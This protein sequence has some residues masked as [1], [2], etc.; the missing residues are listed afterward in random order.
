LAAK[1]DYQD[2]LPVLIRLVLVLCT[3]SGTLGRLMEV[4]VLRRLL[5]YA[6][7]RAAFVR[8]GAQI[9]PDVAISYGVY[10]RSP[11]NVSIG[12]GTRLN[13][14]VRIESWGRVTIGR[15]CMFNDDILILTAQHDIDSVDFGPDIRPVA[16]GDYVWLPHRIVLLPGVQLG[17]AAVIGTGSVVTRNVPPYAIAAGNPA[18]VI[19]ERARLTFRYVPAEW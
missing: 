9:A 5:G 1:T 15:S 4:A 19:R 16:I 8:L 3:S 11:H 7:R 6:G 12:A 13:G 17:E 14:R 10:M 18:R 2:R